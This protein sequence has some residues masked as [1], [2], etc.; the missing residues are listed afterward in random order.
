MLEDVKSLSP[1]YAIHKLIYAA[2]YISDKIKE[3]HYDD[4]VFEVHIYGQGE[5]KEQLSQL[6]HKL[7]L[8]NVVFLKGFIK[9]DDV[10]KVMSQMDI[11]CSTSVHES[12]GVAV[13]EAMA[14]NIPVVVTNIDGYREIIDDEKNGLLVNPDD[15]QE[16]GEALLKLIENE[17]LR[18]MY[19]TNGRK[20][21]EAYYSWW[22]NVDTLLNLLIDNKRT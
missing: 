11:F 19:S 16:I 6:I 10:P 18:K 12:F 3:E 20:H 8:E 4:I 5:L 22:E 13:V 1:V 14:M 21:I 7:D 15:I 9:N 2:K 17:N